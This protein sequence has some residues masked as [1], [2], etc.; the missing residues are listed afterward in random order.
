MLTAKLTEVLLFLLTLRDN[1]EIVQ[2]GIAIFNDTSS[3]YYIF[4]EADGM[5]RGGAENW[6]GMQ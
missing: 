6:G 3:V 5:G 4:S 2:G 1:W